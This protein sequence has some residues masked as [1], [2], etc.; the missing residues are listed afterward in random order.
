[1]DW[2][3][4]GVVALGTFG[5]GALLIWILRTRDL[6]SVVARIA[7]LEAEATRARTL[8]AELETSRA[9]VA[10]LD[11]KLASATTRVENMAG[12]EQDLNA[13]R[14][15]VTDLTGENASLTARLA[16][17][18]ESHA[19]QVG[20]LTR[21]RQEMQDQFKLLAADVLRSSNEDFSKRAVEIFT[22]QKE[23]TAA[24]IDKRSKDISDLVKPLG[25]SLKAY[26]GELKKIEE[27]RKESYGGIREALGLVRSQHDEVRTVTATLVNA[28]RASPKTRGRWGEE[29]LRRVMEMSGMVEHCDFETEK[30]FR[31]DD[32]SL[33]P[34]ALIHVAGG[35]VIVVDAKAPVSAYLDA[36]GAV[37]EDEREKLLKLH[38]AQL[39]ERLT[40]LSAKSYWEK[41]EGSTDCVVM[42][43]PGDNFV[44]AAFERDPDLFEDGIKNRVLICTPTTFI[45]LA[46]AISYGWRQEKLAA[47]AVDVAR[48]GKELYARLTTLG[49]HVSDV[50]RHI[51]NA[52]KKYNAMV[53]SL[54]SS[55]MPHAR[56]FNELGVEGTAKPIETLAEV[57]TVVRFPQANRDLL[58]TKGG[59]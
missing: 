51:N 9:S 18:A 4:T 19:E 16:S 40:N 37:G 22:T 43:V 30:H 59:E 55:V 39:R 14:L 42:F 31:G 38:A 35:R 2:I 1:M 21:L 11:R 41:I 8:A 58:I 3:L 7:P 46:K 56:R 45:A 53:G 6:Q 20:Q 54:E 47:N 15:R 29:T 17:L 24:E 23:L 25:E 44:S 5:I 52:A 32:E 12:L 34:D 49:D 10:D 27:A 36:I 26:E 28:L 48:L 50:G 57:D 33:R 13:A